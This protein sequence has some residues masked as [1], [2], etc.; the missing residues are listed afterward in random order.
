[1]KLTFFRA[2]ARKKLPVSS[3]SIFWAAFNLIPRFENPGTRGGQLCWKAN[4]LLM[5][6][7][8]SSLLIELKNG[9]SRSSQPHLKGSFKSNRP[10]TSSNGYGWEG[11]GS[12]QNRNDRMGL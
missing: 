7:R 9:S 6:K 1:M 11:Q 8:C 10:H 4:R 2:V 12:V 5:P 3:A